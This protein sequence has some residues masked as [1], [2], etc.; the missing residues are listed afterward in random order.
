MKIKILL[1][2]YLVSIL[3]T[4]KLYSQVE[5]VPPSHRI[6]SFLERMYENKIIA[7]YSPAIQPISRRE[8]AKYLR[9]IDFRKLSSTDKKLAEDFAVEF[10]Y[11]I[12]GSLKRTSSFFKGDFNI[13]ENK[14]Q[15]YWYA[16]ADSNVSIFWDG[17]ADL[18][19]YG[20]N[21]DSIGKPHLLLGSVGTRIR[22]TLFNSVG[23]YLRLSNGARLSGNQQDAMF[24][25]TQDPVLASTR[26]FVSEGSKTFDTFEGYL[27]YATASDWLGLTAGR[28]AV[29][30]GTGIIDKLILSDNTAPFDY[31][32]L[33]IS[34][35]KIKYSFFHSSITGFDTSVNQLEA[36]YLVF[37][38]FEIGPLFNGMLRLGFNEMLV[39]SNVPVN[40]AFL[41]PVSFL[42]SADLN[43]ELPG[44]NTN[45]TLI[46]ID[47]L[48]N[49]AKKVSLQGTFLIDDLN[50][51]TLSSDSAKGN[52]NKFGYQ[53]GLSWQDAAT[54]KNL[55]LMYEFTHL[56]PFVYS[57]RDFN[58]SYTNWGQPLGAKLNPNSDEHAVKLAYDF[59]TRLNLAVTFKHQ[60]S[61]MNY[62]DSTGKFINVG[63]DINDGRNDFAQ[64]NIFLNGTRVNRDILTAEIIWQPIRQYYFIL[65]FQNRRYDYPDNK[66][67]LSD[68]IFFGEFK[69]DY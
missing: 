14:K 24:G 66:R 60:R 59:G 37:H 1:P 4:F 36:K 41:N 39:Y 21:G 49:P 38:R 50:F 30:F 57:H 22:G 56:D 52:D 47:A 31:I 62:T 58:N 51:G 55:H 12:K 42:T 48:L 63:S 16:H 17:I 68:N 29:K 9:E 20:A 65:R 64:K 40:F 33:D 19:Y 43:T 53:F 23:Y 5:L 44:K 11:D 3:C 67:K 32:K 26:K 2:I 15:K 69:I 10:E 25:A 7:N 46:A 27:R 34:Y 8:I 18:R 54:V 45:N 13:F 6:Y 35:K 28:E 61:G